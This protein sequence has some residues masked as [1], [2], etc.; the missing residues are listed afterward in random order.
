MSVIP[1]SVSNAQVCAAQLGASGRATMA[2]PCASCRAVL[3]V[4]WSDLLGKR[5]PE[6]PTL[7]KIFFALMPHRQNRCLFIVLYLEQCNITGRPKRNYQ[8]PQERIGLIG[9]SA[10][11][12]H[13]FRKTICFFNRRP[14]ANSCLKII[15]C[16]TFEK[17]PKIPLSGFGNTKL[18][19]HLELLC[20][21]KTASNA[22]SDSALLR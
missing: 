19:A 15:R 18:E 6:L 21:S 2:K 22:A 14:S 7:I 8:F 3:G 16:E 20:F 13:C 12:W 10:S 11:K 17:P 9:F 1:C 4:R 5:R